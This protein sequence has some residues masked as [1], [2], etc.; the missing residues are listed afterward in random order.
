MPGRSR[1]QPVPFKQDDALRAQ[2]AEMIR[3]AEAGR[4]AADYQCPD[5]SVA[6]LRNRDRAKERLGRRAIKR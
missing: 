6:L 4:A 3:K 5:H 1:P 2:A